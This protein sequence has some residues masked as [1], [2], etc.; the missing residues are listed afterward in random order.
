MGMVRTERETYKKLYGRH[1]I[2]RTLRSDERMVG[3]GKEKTPFRVF[4]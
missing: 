2:V 1:D 4:I 3:T